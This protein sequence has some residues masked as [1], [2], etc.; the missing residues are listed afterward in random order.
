MAAILRPWFVVLLF[1]ATAGQA[2]AAGEGYTLTANEVRQIN[3]WTPYL[4]APLAKDAEARLRRVLSSGR[5]ATRTLAAVILFRH[6]GNKY[7]D[8]VYDL[9][10]VREYHQ[11]KRGIYNM[12]DKDRVLNAVGEIEKRNAGVKDKRVFL[13]LAYLTFRGTN[14]WFLAGPRRQKLSPARI[15]RTAFLTAAL[16]G[17]GVDTLSLANDIDRATRKSMGY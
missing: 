14:T 9:Y 3:E 16:K 13:L 7:R 8:A 5:G 11:R 1:V 6:G 12:V 15:F 4:T 17:T 2:A 10:A